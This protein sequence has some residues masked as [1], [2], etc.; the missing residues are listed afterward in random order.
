MD[1]IRDVSDRI[2]FKLKCRECAS[3]MNNYKE[4]DNLTARISSLKT[5]KRLLTIELAMLQKKDEVFSKQNKAR[6]T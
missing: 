3:N 4:C 1:K 2:G 6:S 5:E